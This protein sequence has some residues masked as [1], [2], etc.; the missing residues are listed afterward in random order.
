MFDSFSKTRP[1]MIKM[2]C[3]QRIRVKIPLASGVPMEHSEGAGCTSTR[4]A[5]SSK[6][7]FFYIRKFSLAPDLCVCEMSHFRMKMEKTKSLY[8]NS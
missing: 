8:N 1:L 5:Q 4:A 2:S 3:V 6:S 7:L